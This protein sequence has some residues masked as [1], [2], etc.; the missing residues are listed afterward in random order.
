MWYILMMYMYDDPERYQYKVYS[1]TTFLVGLD[2]AQENY[3]LVDNL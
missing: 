2:L 1:D 3:H